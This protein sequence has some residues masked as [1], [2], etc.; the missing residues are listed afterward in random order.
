MTLQISAFINYVYCIVAR[1]RLNDVATQAVIEWEKLNS[2]ENTDCRNM[3]RA[4]T[5]ICDRNISE[6]CWKTQA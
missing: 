6:T 1:S 3:I 4:T 5:K 2:G